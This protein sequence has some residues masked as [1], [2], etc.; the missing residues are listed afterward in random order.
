MVVRLQRYPGSRPLFED[1]FNFER[2][3]D[4]LFGNFLGT[5]VS[6]RVRAFPAIDLAEYENESVL[7]A[8][9]PGV[10]KED[11][12]ISLENTLL[13]L[14]GVRKENALP[15]GSSRVRNEVEM[16]EFSR[17]IEL[18]HAVEL[19]KVTAEMENGMLRIVLPKPERARPREILV[20]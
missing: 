14:S 7:V 19:D 3:I 11:V 5:G 18:Q 12:K 9:M 6:P 17:S 16:G 10:K 20:H 2:E 13:T 1:L 8:E 4:S 15:E